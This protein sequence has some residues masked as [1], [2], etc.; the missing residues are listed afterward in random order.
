MNVGAGGT[1]AACCTSAIGIAPCDAIAL[2]ISGDI[3][4]GET[5][6]R[7]LCGVTTASCLGNRVMPGRGGEYCGRVTDLLDW[8]RSCPPSDCA[9]RGLLPPISVVLDGSSAVIFLGFETGASS[10]SLTAGEASAG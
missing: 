7:R 8:S 4:P 6:G 9:P 5:G 3:G 10:A 1:G 2:C